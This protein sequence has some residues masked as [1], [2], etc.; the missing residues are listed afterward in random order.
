MRQARPVQIAVCPL[1]WLPLCVVCTLLCMM[2][3]GTRSSPRLGAP[4][5]L[6]GGPA[7]AQLSVRFRTGRLFSSA[8]WHSDGTLQTVLNRRSRAGPDGR[9][10]SFVAQ[11]P[12]R[13]FAECLVASCSWPTVEASPLASKL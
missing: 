8:A 7:V 6:R 1:T 11:G 5:Q 13:G 3:V 9:P 10:S 4:R 12:G 2:C